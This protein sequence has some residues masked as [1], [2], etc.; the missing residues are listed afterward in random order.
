M[1]DILIFSDD[2][3]SHWKHL[4][5]VLCLLQQHFIHI[6]WLKSVFCASSVEFLGMTVSCGS[7]KPSSVILNKL[8][9][10]LETD[11]SAPS[12]WATVQGLLQQFQRCGPRFNVLVDRYRNGSPAIRR[13]ILFQLSSWSFTNVIC[14]SYRL[15]TDW[16]ASGCGY[17]LFS[18]SGVPLLWNSHRNNPSESRFSSFLGELHAATWAMAD[19]LLIWRGC[20]LSIVSDNKGF[21]D[22][23]HRLHIQSDPR[24]LRRLEFILAFSDVSISF[25][26]GFFNNFADH[27]SRM[28]SEDRPAPKVAVMEG[29][30]SFDEHFKWAHAGHWGVEKTLLN[31]KRQGVAI[32]GMEH[33]VRKRISRCR[34]CQFYSQKK[35]LSQRLR[36]TMFDA[37][38]FDN[39]VGCDFIGP[40]PPSGTQRYVFVMID[41]FS[42]WVYWK[43]FAQAI[44]K[45]A[46]KC[47][48]VWIAEFGS[49]ENLVTDHASYFVS[50]KFRGWCQENGINHFLCPPH[51]HK[52]N[53]CCER[54]VKTLL[55]RVRVLMAESGCSWT[56]CMA[57]ALDIYHNTPHRSTTYSPRELTFGYSRTGY[58]ASPEELEEWRW[59]AYQNQKR[60]QGRSHA[61]YMKKLSSVALSV[62]D[63]VLL[64]DS[65]RAAALDRKFDAH[66]RGPF[67]LHSQD[68]RCTWTLRSEDG[69]VFHNI[70]SDNLKLH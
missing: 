66:W 56:K 29:T 70:H 27:F 69:R 43:S 65:V 47:L 14:S 54:V 57:P 23:F 12:Q 24:I 6:N 42:E 4:H 67:I 61:S 20:S 63:S 45:N 50:Q 13:S 46:V 1:D 21:V 30:V 34:V 59:K 8:F 64:F 68:S 58:Q 48:Q 26:P 37:D 44:W 31:L 52:T 3:T 17:V 15:F 9:S 11:C 25:V 5:Q 7:I 62:G 10:L 32:Q 28:A 18:D 2:L 36:D 39:M 49:M 33:E 41:G 51:S 19:S 16:S 55:Q 40:L 53:G 60:A 38:Q 35:I 22:N